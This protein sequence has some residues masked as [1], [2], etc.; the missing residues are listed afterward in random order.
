MSPRSSTTTASLSG[1]T[2]SGAAPPRSV[3]SSTSCNIGTFSKAG[4]FDG[5]IE[6][7][8]YLA[9]LGITHVEVMPVAGWAGNQGWGYDSVALFTTHEPYGGPDGS[10]ALRRRLP[11][12]WASRSSWMSF[13]TT[14]GRSGN[15]TN[16]FGPYL[17]KDR[18]T[19][20]GDA[21]NLDGEGSDEVRRF[22]VDNALMWLKDYHCDGLQIRRSSRL[23]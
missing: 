12:Q 1:T 18:K 7:L 20:W 4:T 15:Y 10:Q 16:K 11:R 5:A 19:P 14:S 2:S 21:V 9:D 22:F 3:P 17:T 23:P 13:T 6:H 8:P